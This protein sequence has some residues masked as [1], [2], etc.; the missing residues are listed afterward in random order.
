MIASAAC[1][2]DLEEGRGWRDQGEADEHL[3]GVPRE[4]TEEQIGGA[5]GASSSGAAGTSEDLQG[6]GANVREGSRVQPR[7]GDSQNS[8]Y[9]ETRDPKFWAGK[10][11]VLVAVAVLLITPA[12][13]K[14]WAGYVLPCAALQLLLLS[15]SLL[16]TWIFARLTKINWQHR[17]WANISSDPCEDS[18]TFAHFQIRIRANEEIS[19]SKVGDSQPKVVCKPKLEGCCI[20]MDEEPECKALLPC[21]HVF[22]EDCIAHWAVSGSK[23]SHTCP[24]CRSPFDLQV[25]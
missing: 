18:P 1:A 22:C 2:G 11:I 7:R 5:A 8:L 16:K 23:E 24:V 3:A 9:V 10:L 6:S 4:R 13:K 17:V 14:D 15:V 20:C 12:V 25:V 21:G 19:I